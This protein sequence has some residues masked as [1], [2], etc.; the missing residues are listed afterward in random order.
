MLAQL[1]PDRYLRI[2]RSSVVDAD[3]IV[4][5]RRRATGSYQ[6]IMRDGTVLPVGRS[7]RAV[8]RKLTNRIS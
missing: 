8:V 7:Y 2:H 5:V 3:A 6:A 1:E 4:G